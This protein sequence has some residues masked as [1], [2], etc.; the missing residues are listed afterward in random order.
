MGRHASRHLARQ[1][2]SRDAVEQAAARWA[3]LTGSSAARLET[4]VHTTTRD[5]T[6]VVALVTVQLVT[7]PEATGG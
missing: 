3:T 2:R 5:G 1:A 6:P 4:T 7:D